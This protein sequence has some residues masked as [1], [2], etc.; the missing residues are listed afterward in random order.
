[1][2]IVRSPLEINELANV[3]NQECRNRSKPSDTLAQSAPESTAERL[4]QKPTS[5]SASSPTGSP[6]STDTAAPSAGVSVVN[7]LAR[8]AAAHIA[9][10]T[11]ASAAREK[12]D[13]LRFAREKADEAEFA[14]RLLYGVY[15]KELSAARAAHL[16]A[17]AAFAFS[18]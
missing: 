16:A 15:K 9:A 18:K 17:S 11:A 1:M 6:K 14:A 12:L 10:M 7:D 5:G 2:F 3:K 13:A 4:A 8:A